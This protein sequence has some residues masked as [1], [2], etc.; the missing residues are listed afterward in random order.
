MQLP[1]VVSAEEWTAAHQALLAKEKRATRT[2]DA[3]AA[4]RRR[5]PMVSFD[6]DYVFE[7]RDGNTGLLEMFEGRRQL[8]VY[9]FMLEPGAPGWPD[10]GCDGCSMFVDN[11][12][13]PAHLNTRDTTMALVS[14]ARST[15]SSATASVWAGEC[16]GTRSPATASTTTAGSVTSSG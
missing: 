14:R 12:G 9:H 16:P 6:S 13:H 8:M 5:L 2:R 3:L 4:E 10:A 11:L 7:G 1:Q 15:R